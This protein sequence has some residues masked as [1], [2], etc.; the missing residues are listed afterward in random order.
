MKRR[1]L[2]NQTSDEN[3]VNSGNTCGDGLVSPYKRLKVSE[4]SGSEVTCQG[5]NSD[6]HSQLVSSG[7]SSRLT[8]T[9]DGHCNSSCGSGGNP[10]SQ[11]EPAA[12]AGGLGGTAHFGPLGDFTAEDDKAGVTMTGPG[13][14]AGV[15]S[16][17]LVPLRSAL[18]SGHPCSLGKGE[19]TVAESV[20]SKANKSVKFRDCGAT[21]SSGEGLQTRGGAGCRGAGGTARHPSKRKVLET[22]GKLFLK[23]SSLT[24]MV[25]R[26]Q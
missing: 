17:H 24:R 11:G 1:E 4:V 21:D 20:S 6:P 19:V 23:K 22:E 9:S 5:L 8:N 12:I 15:D 26:E 25:S 3:D 10:V 18:V 2:L 14:S 16:N 7:Y 13:T